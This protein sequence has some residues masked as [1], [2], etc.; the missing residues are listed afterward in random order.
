MNN[1][2][3]NTFITIQILFLKMLFIFYVHE[4]FL[5]VCIYVQN[6]IVGTPEGRRWCIESSSTVVVDV[7]MLGTKPRLQEQQVPWTNETSLQSSDRLLIG[8]KD[9]VL[10]GKRIFKCVNNTA[11]EYMKQIVIPFKGGLSK[12]A[13]I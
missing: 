4:C 3:R 13:M 1:W 8:T 12:G 11:S 5:P 2:N 7:G 9:S 6:A 10:Q